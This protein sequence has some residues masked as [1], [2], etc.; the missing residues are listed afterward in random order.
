MNCAYTVTEEEI[1]DEGGRHTVFGLAVCTEDGAPLA[2]L[3]SLFF[4]REKAE[5]FSR[6]CE[7]L[8]LSPRHLLEVADD[9]LAE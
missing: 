4:S 9:L 1:E 2:H 5:S 6:L 3:P 8:A 7:R